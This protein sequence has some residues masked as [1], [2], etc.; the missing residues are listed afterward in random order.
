MAALSSR[1]AG[2]RSLGARLL[3][4]LLAGVAGTAGSFA[5]AGFAPGFVVEPLAS[6]ATRLLPGPVVTFVVLVFGSLGEQLAVVAALVAA[7]GLLSLAALVGLVVGERASWPVG[8]PLA[9]VLVCGV[10]VALTSA[11]V[12]SVAAG[13]GAGLVVATSALGPRVVPG[14]S[15]SRRR[16]LAGVAAGVGVTALG[17]V[18][19]SRRRGGATPG[20][21]GDRVRVERLLAEADAKSLDVPGLEPLVSES[22]YQVDVDPVDPTVAAEDWTLAITG[23]VD[24]PVTVDYADLRSMAADH[25]FVTLRC[26]GE[27]LNGRKLDTALWTGVPLAPLVERARPSADRCC[28]VLRAADGYYESFP[29]EALADAFLAYGMNGAALPRA[30]GFPAR[31]L[32]PGHWGEINVKWLT[33]IEVRER[34]AQSYWEQRGWHG[35]GPVETVAKLH[36]VN[37]DGGRVQVAGHAY[38]GTRGVDRVEVS[39]DGGAT[40]TDARLSAPLPGDDVWRQWVHEYDAPGRRHEVVVRAVDGT[41]TRQPREERSPFPRGPTGWVTRTVGP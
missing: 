22:F 12:P 23:A 39:T 6:L 14:A 16:V 36:V 41:G 32:V 11:P 26:V 37:R 9:A 17:A 10:A 15:P 3:V 18:L 28:V 34:E 8:P 13:A 2:A 1:L 21:T 31:A 24:R 7:V 30:H 40:W 4:A 35:T 25:R 20:A 33:E 38:A 19:G 27:R 5:A 29:I